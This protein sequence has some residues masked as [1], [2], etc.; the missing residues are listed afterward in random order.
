VSDYYYASWAIEKLEQNHDQPFFLGVGFVRPHVPWYVP[1]HWLDM[2]PLENIQL[3]P[4][5]EDDMEDIPEVG[6][7]MAFM[8]P[9]P[10][11][12][13][14]KEQGQWKEMI[15]A[16]LASITFMDHQLGRVLRALEESPYADNTIIVLFSD[17]GYHLGEKNRVAKM[18]LW[19]RDT[20]VP[21]I[22]SGPGIDSNLRS[23][24]PVGLIDI[25]PTL[26]DLSHLPENHQNE[27]QS[28]TPLMEDVD[29]EWPYPVI[30]SFGPGNISLRSDR[31]RYIQYEDGSEEFYDHRNDPNEWHNLAK[32][33]K[34]KT[35]VKSEIEKLQ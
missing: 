5:L 10:T 13:Y 1:Q 18:S 9:M 17:H 32:D 12:D 29:R 35:K 3:P 14:L 6:Q 8:P 34:H 4:Y 2:Y 33:A 24:R 19:E 30:T 27:G 31:F 20:R 7:R 22:F 11:R 26:L 15:Q 25:Y 23:S 16:Y 28:L 21:L